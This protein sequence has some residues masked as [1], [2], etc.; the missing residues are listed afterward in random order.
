MVEKDVKFYQRQLDLSNRDEKNWRERGKNIIKKYESPSSFNILWSNTQTQFPAMYSSRPKPDVRRRWKGPSPVG[1][2]IAKAVER[3]LEFSMDSYDFDRMAEKCTLDYLLPGRQV[4]RVK[5]H[6]V[7]IDKEFS[8]TIPD[9]IEPPE[10]SVKQD[11]GSFV[12]SRSFR[13][14]VHEEVRVYHVPWDQYRYSPADCWDDVWWVAYGDN[15]LTQDEITEQFG[16]EHKDVPLNFT[17]ETKDDAEHAIKRA[18]VWELWDR[19]AKKVV[20]VIN[21]YDKFLMNEKDPLKLRKFFPQPEPAMMIEAPNSLIPIPEFTMYQNQANDLNEISERISNLTTAMKLVGF[22]PGEEQ[23]KVKEALK[24]KENTL[25]PIDN[26]AAFAEKG[27]IKGMIDYLPIKEVADVWQRLIVERQNLTQSIFE[28]IGISDIQRGS[29]DPRETKGA[30]QLKANFAGRRLLPKQQRSQRFYRDLL[31]ISAEIIAEHFSAKTL[32]GMTGTEVTEDMLAIMRNDALRSFTIDIETDSTVAADD[33]TEKQGVAE[34]VTSMSGFL[35]QAMPLVQ[36][37]PAAAEPLGK[38]LL[39]MSRKFKISRDVEE[40]VESFVEAIK[41]QPS[42]QNAEEDAK[43]AE[44]EKKLS[45]LEQEKTKK[46]EI[47]EM[48]SQREQDRKDR[49]AAAEI[50]RKDALAQ[51]EIDRK[52]EQMNVD[53]RKA[54]QDEKKAN[55]QIRQMNAKTKSAM[56]LEAN[57]EP[58]NRS[59]K[60]VKDDDGKIIGAEIT[61]GDEVEAVTIER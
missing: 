41:S 32:Q 36:A 10:G 59:I 3:A 9:G 54:D 8:E 28:L 56:G 55:A 4:A 60:M 58:I 38:M 61:N 49:E 43:K 6:P 57:I 52:N 2:E 12:F 31:R 25:V 48:E 24:S 37:A 13:E 5:Y 42:Q 11:D 30:Q 20:A 1:R 19:D 15:F 50:A 33:E 7:I 53:R 18:Q 14:K 35:A 39:W 17:D 27:G 46:L 34:F 23:E 29:T 16:E 40:E 22:Y 45:L 21:G 26:W 51:A 47:D 44:L